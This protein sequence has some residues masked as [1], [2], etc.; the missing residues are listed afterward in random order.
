MPDDKYCYANSNVLKNKLGLRD[1]KE[2]LL[3]EI[4]FTSARLSYLQSNPIEGN[5]DF[6]HLKKIHKYIFQ[7]LYDWAGEKRTVEIGKGNIFCL[8]NYL[9]EYAKTV[10]SKYYIQCKS[11]K[12]SR[13]DFIY[14]LAENY[15][16]LNALHPFREGN[17]RTQREFARTLCLDCGYSFDISCTSHK[18]MLTA[19]ILS[20]NKGD[21]SGFKHIFS[22]AVEPLGNHTISDRLV[23]PTSDDLESPQNEQT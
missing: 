5:F 16:N 7:D 4:K 2:L 8:T 21:N 13:E 20:F 19:S 17:G 9:D 11:S 23:I 10:F 1:P 14:A 6:N 12:D 22:K 15:S 3:T 18:E